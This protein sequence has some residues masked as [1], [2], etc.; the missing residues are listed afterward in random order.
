MKFKMA[1]NS[2]FAILLRSPWWM[3]IG[4]AGAIALVARA[5][6][7]E[8]LFTVGALAGFPFLVIGAVAG[9]RQFKAPSA[10]QVAA[11]LDKARAMAWREF[12]ATV[13]QALRRDGHT[14]T[15]L[16]GPAADFA[17][18]QGGRTM[19]VSARRWKAAS[20][21]IEPLRELHTAATAREAS[22]SLY[23]A[24]GDL[25]DPARRFASQNQ[26]RV[27]QGAEL[28]GWLGA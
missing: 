20:H 12:A 24:L 13:E 8:N 4:L 7:P 2:L 11:T 5:A 14:V 25:S 28:A 16:D 27:L 15:R 10:S 17:V 26:I 18:V 3:S 19:L 1:P 22:E 21:G 6:L 9:W 23:L